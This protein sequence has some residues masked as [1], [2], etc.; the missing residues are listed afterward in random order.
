[1]ALTKKDLAK[2]LVACAGKDAPIKPLAN[3]KQ[4]RSKKRA[5]EASKLVEEFGLCPISLQPMRRPVLPSSGQAYDEINIVRYC[6]DTAGDKKRRCPVSGAVL[7]FSRGKVTRTPDYALRKVIRH[8]AVQAKVYIPPIDKDELIRE[9]RAAISSECV[10][11]L[12]LTKAV[13]DDAYLGYISI[14]ELLALLGEALAGSAGSGAP[15]AAALAVYRSLVAECLA[16]RAPAIVDVGLAQLALADEAWTCPRVLEEAL[17]VGQDP[18]C[19]GQVLKIVEAQFQKKHYT[20]EQAAAV[21]NFDTES[22]PLQQEQARIAEIMLSNGSHGLCK[23]QDKYVGVLNLALRVR[24]DLSGCL[25]NGACAFNLWSTAMLALRKTGSGSSL[26][27]DNLERLFWRENHAVLAALAAEQPAL[28]EWH[29]GRHKRALALC[30]AQIGRDP[31]DGF[32]DVEIAGSGLEYS[33][34]EEMYS[35]IEELELPLRR[36]GGGPHSGGRA[37]LGGFPGAGQGRRV[38]YPDLPE[39]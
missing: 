37:D 12:A 21:L 9:L 17:S 39:H 11:D 7:K 28:L 30:I 26:D 20:P 35:D 19:R 16:C 25:S 24:S 36:G 34:D 5:R 4:S 22:V 6:S 29:L 13:V 10:C 2:K 18:D 15:A 32:D 38:I 8:Q 27:E 33:S 1:M 3:K 14:P 31:D 23:P